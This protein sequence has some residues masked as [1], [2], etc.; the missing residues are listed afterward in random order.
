MNKKVTKRHCFLESINGLFF[1]IYSL[2]HKTNICWIAEQHTFCVS[3]LLP[4]TLGMKCLSTRSHSSR[5]VQ[6]VE[7]FR[8]DV[9]L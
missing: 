8:V 1:Y 5:R 4:P 2:S 3:R 7:N 9:F 6:K